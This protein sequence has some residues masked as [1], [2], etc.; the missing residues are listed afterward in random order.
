MSAINESNSNIIKHLLDAEQDAYEINKITDERPDMTTTEAYKLQEDLL[1]QRLQNN[2]TRKIGVKLGL[3]NKTKQQMMNVDE[4][5]IGDLHADMLAYE[6]EPLNYSALIHP[7]VEPEIAFFIGEDLQGESITE[8]DV[9][10]ATKYIAPAFEVIDSRY[11]DFQFNLADV[12][13]DNCSSS[14]FIVGS[15]LASP[16][17][18]DLNNIG[19]V[20]SKNGEI[21]QTGS[22]AAV[23][24][25]PIKALRWAVSTLNKRGKKIKKGDI[26]LSGSLTEAIKIEGGDTIVAHFDG[27]G[28]TSISCK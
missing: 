1:K 11:Q 17:S 6:W 22:S 25:H 19:V 7:K 3:T 15:K 4:A 24:D 28:S 23:L 26:V 10:R 9:I 16:H 8:T 20:M 13:V 18:V 27:L 21:K 2:D 5:I 12:I 14:K